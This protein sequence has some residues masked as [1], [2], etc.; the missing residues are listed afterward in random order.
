MQT[1]CPAPQPLELYSNDYPSLQ[2]AEQCS[3]KALHTK[4]QYYGVTITLQPS[5]QSNALNMI[6]HSN[7]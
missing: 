7:R 2:Q 4:L 6:Q 1:K 5:T 3:E